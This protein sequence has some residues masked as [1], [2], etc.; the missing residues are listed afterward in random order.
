MR[1]SLTAPKPPPPPEHASD[2]SA[3]SALRMELNM[4]SR[5]SVENRSS[6]NQGEKT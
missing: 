1:S 4:R 3:L 6:E 2:E 5:G